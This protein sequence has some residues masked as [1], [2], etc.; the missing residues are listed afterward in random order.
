M[1][2]MFLSLIIWLFLVLTGLAVSEQSLPFCEPDYDGSP[3]VRLS[4]GL[5]GGLETLICEPGCEGP[6]V[7]LP[8]SEIQG[9]ILSICVD[10]VGGAKAQD[11]LLGAVTDRTRTVDVS[12]AGRDVCHPLGMDLGVPN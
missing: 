7:N 10:R 2:L 4:L 8:V 11:L 1:V 6:P 12:P 5:G 3:L 9:F